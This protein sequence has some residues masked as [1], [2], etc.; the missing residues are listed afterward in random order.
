MVT[1]TVCPGDGGNVPQVTLSPSVAM[2]TSEAS[3]EEVVEAVR[4]G[5]E[6]ACVQGECVNLA[7]VL[8]L[9]KGAYGVLIKEGSTGH[10]IYSLSSLGPILAFPVHNV[11][12]EVTSLTLGT[13]TSLAMLA[14][15]VSDCVSKVS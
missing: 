11:R 7:L 9:T 1:V 12:I 14:N 15:C 6:S 8:P 4:G 2:E 10:Y 3:R 5:M 13:G